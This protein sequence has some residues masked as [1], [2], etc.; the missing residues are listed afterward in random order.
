[1]LRRL[2]IVVQVCWLGRGNIL[3]KFQELLPASVKFLYDR[4]DLVNYRILGGN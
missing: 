3:F 4:V 1:M 2:G